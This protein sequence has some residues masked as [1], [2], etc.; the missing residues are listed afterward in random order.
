MGYASRTG[1]RAG[2]CT[3]FLFYNI[4]LEETT[5]LRVYP[6]TVM[7]VTLKDYLHVTPEQAIDR[8]K[9]IIDEVKNVQGTFISLWHNESLSETGEWKGWSRVYTEMLKYAR[10]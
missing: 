2:T 7:D 5:S 6:F 4:H 8:V 10:V 1:F 9:K 3:P